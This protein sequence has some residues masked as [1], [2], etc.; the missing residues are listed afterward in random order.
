MVVS[1][2]RVHTTVDI[3]TGGGVGGIVCAPELASGNIVTGSGT[4]GTSDGYPW[5]R[6][7]E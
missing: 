3:D 1:D 6:I 5:V 7:A 4:A 2:N